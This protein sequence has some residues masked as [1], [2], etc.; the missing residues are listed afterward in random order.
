M[1]NPHISFD[2]NIPKSKDDLK[3]II[4]NLNKYVKAELF[5]EDVYKCYFMKY[6]NYNHDIFIKDFKLKL[7]KWVVIIILFSHLKYMILD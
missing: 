7:I 2:F 4:L 5:S 6:L 3:N 1:N